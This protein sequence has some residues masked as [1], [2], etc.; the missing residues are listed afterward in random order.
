MKKLSILLCLVLCSLCVHSQTIGTINT[1]QKEV[2]IK[3]KIKVFPNPATNVVNVLGLLNS[4]RAN[5]VI[6]DTYG[7]TVLQHHWAIKEKAL[8]I[9]VAQ[10][11][12]GIYII[13]IISKEQQVQTKF[14]KK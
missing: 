7:N 11:N 10:L 8:S 2:N 13:T 14:Y 4:N 1:S 6:S 12:S 5:I 3:Q 9:P